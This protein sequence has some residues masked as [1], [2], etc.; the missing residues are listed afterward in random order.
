MMSRAVLILLVLALSAGSA[1]AGKSRRRHR[2]AG[3][4]KAVPALNALGLPNVQSRSAI[5]I[6]VDSG[7][8]HF[9]KNPDRVRY[10]ASTTKIFLALAVRRRGL[11]LASVTTITMDDV[12]S[13][14]G[15]AR[16]RLDVGEAYTGRDL[17][18]VMLVA[19]DNRA[20]T[21][22]GRAVGL[23]RAGLVSEMNAV[24]ADLG[25][26]HTTFTD[27]SGLNGNVSTARE[28]AIAMR[29][30][31][32]DPVLAEVIAT[33]F[34]SINRVSHKRARVLHYANTNRTLHRASYHSLGGKT[35]YTNEAKYCL[36]TASQVG[37]RRLAFVFL[38]AD[39]ELTRYGDFNRVW[40]WMES[41]GAIPR[42]PVDTLT[43]G[44]AVVEA[45][46][47]K[48]EAAP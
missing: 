33:K 36:V 27:A 18:H 19:S 5:V 25:L 13:A 3:A 2:R 44:T 31:L 8:L 39:G 45:G 4:D 1:D 47:Q 42:D 40:T 7:K 24:A 17:L 41:T 9:G 35:G 20:T 28:M 21:A 37:E 10:I 32:D 46:G 38:G 22:L 34:T 26:T 14:R 11:D 23:D 6:D 12:D 15:G 48:I 43:T 30:V 16:T 29:A